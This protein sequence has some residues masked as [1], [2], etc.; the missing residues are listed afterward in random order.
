M[1]INDIAENVSG[2]FATSMGSGNGFKSGGI[3]II[4][5]NKKKAKESVYA[6]NKEEPNNPEVLVP[7]YGRL[8]MDQLKRMCKDMLEGL[9]KFAEQ[10]NWERVEYEMQR[11]T[12]MPKLNAL[13]KALEDLETIRKKGGPQSRGITKR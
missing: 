3:G 6:M 2:A 10:D 4:R 9:A 8:G 12:F 1:K 13:V 11:G 7:G 5:R